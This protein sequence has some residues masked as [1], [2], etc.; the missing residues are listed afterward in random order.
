[1]FCGGARIYQVQALR[2]SR[3]KET[4]AAS[5]QVLMELRQLTSI[6]L[7]LPCPRRIGHIFASSLP[8]NKHDKYARQAA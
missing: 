6:S 5:G 4:D 2:R 8:I 7:H 1:M 3:A